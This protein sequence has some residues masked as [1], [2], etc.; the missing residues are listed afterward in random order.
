[1]LLARLDAAVRGTLT[2]VVAP[3]GWGKTVTL[4]QWARKHEPAVRWFD[5]AVD[6]PTEI[7]AAVADA[8]AVDGGE[9]FVVVDSAA[10]LPAPELDALGALIEQ[11]PP[12]VHVVLAARYGG[13]FPGVVARLR[14]R[15]DAAFLYTPELAFDRDISSRVLAELS[16]QPVPA[17]VV[18]TLM[19][20]TAGWPAAIALAGVAMRERGKPEDVAASFGGH[21]PQLRAFV[22]EDVL[23][24][25]EPTLRSAV[26]RAA[27]PDAIT[28]SLCAELTG[29]D[30]G[31]DLLDRIANYELFDE[32]PTAPGVREFSPLLRDALRH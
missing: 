16:A 14:I 27:V 17:G 7:V 31:D 26:L 4:A 21:D 30:D 2:F 3:A 32:R 10:R 24:V 5:A 13:L 18:E 19:Q 8:I 25:L 15:D 20:K 23:A 1:M 12:D 22:R 6:A 28:A 9:R 29:R 11:A